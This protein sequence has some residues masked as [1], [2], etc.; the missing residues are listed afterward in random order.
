[1]YV[2]LA[3]SIRAEPVLQQWY[4]Q[5]IQNISKKHRSHKQQLQNT[6]GKNF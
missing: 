5:K 3:V 6:W 4:W 2:H 1:M